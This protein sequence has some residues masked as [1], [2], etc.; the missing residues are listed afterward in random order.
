MIVA[1][2]GSISDAMRF[3]SAST[4]VQGRATGL[5]GLGGVQLIATDGG[6]E[7][8]GRRF[9]RTSRLH[10]ASLDCLFDDVEAWVDHDEHQCVSRRR[11]SRGVSLGSAPLDE[12]RRAQF[13][14][15][16][17]AKLRGD[18]KSG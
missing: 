18:P 2:D 13:I 16:S 10:V 7:R 8:L 15:Q 9:I 5:E 14:R 3:I 11:A 1:T 6:L 12:Q 17:L 4:S